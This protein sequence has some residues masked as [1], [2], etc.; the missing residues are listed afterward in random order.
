MLGMDILQEKKLNASVN[1][2]ESSFYKKY[3]SLC[4]SAF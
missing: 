3:I 1:T 2:E 4:Y